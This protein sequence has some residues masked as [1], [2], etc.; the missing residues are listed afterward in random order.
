MLKVTPDAGSYAPIT[1][2]IDGDRTAY[3]SRTTEWPASFAPYRTD[4]SLKVARE[5]DVKVES[6]LMAAAG[7]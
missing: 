2:L 1:V 5:L 6:L 3:I 4:E 7:C